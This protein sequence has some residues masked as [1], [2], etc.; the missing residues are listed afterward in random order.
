MP[1]RQLNRSW[2]FLKDPTTARIQALP[3]ENLEA[4]LA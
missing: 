4:W 3:M 2:G 1:L